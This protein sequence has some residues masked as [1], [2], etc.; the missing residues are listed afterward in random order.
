MFQVIDKSKKITVFL[1]RNI[2]FSFKQLRERQIF[3][4]RFA[5]PV[6]IQYPSMY[7]NQLCSLNLFKISI[8]ISWRATFYVISGKHAIESDFFRIFPCKS[9]ENMILTSLKAPN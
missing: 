9:R 2:K 1:F 6:Q 3:A 7:I 4:F 8:C 5:T